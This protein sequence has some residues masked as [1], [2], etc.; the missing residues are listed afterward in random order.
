M[1]KIFFL[2]L[3]LLGILAI[4]VWSCEP[5]AEEEDV[6]QSFEVIEDLYPGCEIPSICCPTDGGDCYIVNPSG[7]DYYCDASNATEEDPDGCAAAEDQYIDEKCTS[8]MSD[9][10][11]ENLKMDLRRFT[12]ELMAKARANSICL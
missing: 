4:V 11:R 12:Q 6:C 7:D 1:K 9:K 10:E 3:T 5:I 2:P 8:K